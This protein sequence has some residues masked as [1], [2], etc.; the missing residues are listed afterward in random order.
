DQHVAAAVLGDVADLLADGVRGALVPVGRLV[1]LLGGQHLDEAAAERVELVGVGDVPV[2]A[3]AEELGQDVDAVAAAVD[4]VADGDV[5]EP[6]LAGD[7]DGR[8]AA[9]LRERVQPGAAAAAEDEAQD[10]LHGNLAGPVTV[11]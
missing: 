8:L 1:G 7:G 11:G 10:L 2:Q 5:A 9:H 6:V 3:N 4:A